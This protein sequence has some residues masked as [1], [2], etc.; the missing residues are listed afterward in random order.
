M[1]E[2]VFTNHYECVCILCPWDENENENSVLHPINR[3]F[4]RLD[5]PPP[6]IVDFCLESRFKTTTPI[7]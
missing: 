7:K 5:I 3:L 4:R 6:K 2:A 1:A